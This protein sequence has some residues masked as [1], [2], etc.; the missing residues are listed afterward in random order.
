MTSLE[1]VSKISVIKIEQG[2]AKNGCSPSGVQVFFK[3]DPCRG[4]P[5]MQY[6]RKLLQANGFQTKEG[7]KVVG[8]PF[9]YLCVWKHDVEVKPDEVKAVLRADP[10]NIGVSSLSHGDGTS[11]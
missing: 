10:D 9:Y 4:N 8:V 1:S 6:L 3:D 11:G 7:H 5:K 2:D